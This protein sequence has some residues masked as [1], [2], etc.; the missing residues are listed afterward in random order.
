MLLADRADVPPD[1]V[2]AMTARATPAMTTA[3]MVRAL[4]D[5]SP[6]RIERR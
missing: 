6:K 5:D 1:A 2:D 4:M 3:L